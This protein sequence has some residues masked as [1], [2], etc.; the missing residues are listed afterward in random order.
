[1]ASYWF[2]ATEEERRDI[3]WSL[4]AL[5]GLVYDLERQGIVGLIPGPAVLPVLALG[6][7]PQWEQRDDGLWLREE[8][9]QVHSTRGIGDPLLAPPY[10]RRVLTARQQEEAL[11][12]LRSGM[13]AQRAGD[14]FGVSYWVIF[15]LMKR[16]EPARLPQH[17]PTL[18][19]EQEAEARELL[20]QGKTLRQVGAHFGVSYGAIWR[21]VRR[22][23][24]RNEE[25]GDA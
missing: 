9:R 13:S 1:M 23:R 19:P 17:K 14:R 15:R 8:Y 6:L 10:R 7:E 21:M 3:V 11:E 16:Y 2:E 5:E 22:D 24:T 25:G 4:L 20:R 18:T 12:L